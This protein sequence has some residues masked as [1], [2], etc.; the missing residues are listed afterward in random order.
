MVKTYLQNSTLKSA[1]NFTPLHSINYTMPFLIDFLHWQYDTCLYTNIVYIYSVVSMID[2]QTKKVLCGLNVVFNKFQ[3][4][5]DVTGNS[6][7]TFIVLLL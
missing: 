3:P 2:M 1:P 5:L 4:F 6:M 7:H